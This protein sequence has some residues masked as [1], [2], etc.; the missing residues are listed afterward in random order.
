[1]ANTLVVLEQE[2]PY[3]LF[4]LSPA[5]ARRMKQTVELS[6]DTLDAIVASE[7]KQLMGYKQD[8]IWDEPI[9]AKAVQDAAAVIFDYFGGVTAHSGRADE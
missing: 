4:P 1:M 7:M 9:Y 3:V 6:D 2:A 5:R 8:E